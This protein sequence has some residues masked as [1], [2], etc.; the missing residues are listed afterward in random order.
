MMKRVNFLTDEENKEIEGR[1]RFNILPNLL[2]FNKIML[3][4]TCYEL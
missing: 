2:L 3:K 1:K 4:Y